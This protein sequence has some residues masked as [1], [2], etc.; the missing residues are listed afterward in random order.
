MVTYS[1]PPLSEKSVINICINTSVFSVS[2]WPGRLPSG[3]S[4]VRCDGGVEAGVVGGGEAGALQG[5]GE[6]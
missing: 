5:W 3:R 4:P 6:G 2:E 1:N